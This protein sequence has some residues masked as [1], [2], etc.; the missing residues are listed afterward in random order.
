MD[1]IKVKV[2][3][4]KTHTAKTLAKYYGLIVLNRSLPKIHPDGFIQKVCWRV[5]RGLG[6]DRSDIY[7][8]LKTVDQLSEEERKLIYGSECYKL[9]PESW[10][11]MT[12]SE[13]VDWYPPC[14][15]IDY[16]FSYYNEVFD[17]MERQYCTVLPGQRTLESILELSAGAIPDKDSPTGFISVHDR[18]YCVKWEG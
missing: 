2:K 16:D 4:N 17:S 9:L 3:T 13:D 18:I 14:L 11:G 12:M 15:H 10:R 1:W 7:P 8:I 6:D 5:L